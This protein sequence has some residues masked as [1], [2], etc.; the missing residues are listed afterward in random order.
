MKK[1]N[2]HRAFAG[3]LTAVAVMCAAVL[4]KAALGQEQTEA[5][6]GTEAE[7]LVLNTIEQRN[8]GL[9]TVVRDNGETA[10][11]YEGDFDI[12][13]GADGKTYAMLY[14][15]EGQ[16]TSR[17]WIRRRGSGTWWIKDQGR[18]PRHR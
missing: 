8:E 14:L 11:Q 16:D 9:L 13:I 17:N 2:M 7:P 1:N 6:P 18:E 12:W 15:E 5:E 10:F 3:L 4:G